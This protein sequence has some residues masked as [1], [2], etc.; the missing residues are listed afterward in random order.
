MKATLSNVFVF[1]D[2]THFLCVSLCFQVFVL[3]LAGAVQLYKLQ[4]RLEMLYCVF[5]VCILTCLHIHY[6][7]FETRNILFYILLTVRLVTSSW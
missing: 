2:L 3:K 1:P 6:A 4:T 7:Y 5:V